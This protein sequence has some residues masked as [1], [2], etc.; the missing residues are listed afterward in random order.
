MLDGITTDFFLKAPR[1]TAFLL[2]FQVYVSFFI[3]I[4]IVILFKIFQLKFS[5]HINMAFCFKYYD[6]TYISIRKK[7]IYV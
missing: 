3:T 5:F 4:F 1:I 6:T 7:T 2:C